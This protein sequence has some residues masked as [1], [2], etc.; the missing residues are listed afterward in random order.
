MGQVTDTLIHSGL[1][2]IGTGGIANNTTIHAGS[3]SVAGTANTTL[4]NSSATQTVTSGGIAND[5][6]VNSGG[7]QFISSGGTANR[8]E[9]YSA[10]S[11]TIQTGGVASAT[12]LHGG[13]QT[14]LSGGAANDTTINS[15]GLQTVSSGGI[16]TSTVIN[17]SGTQNISAGGSASIT[18][19]E[20]GG[21]QTVMG[22][23][24]DTTI[25]SGG[26]QSV[27]G[28]A[29]STLINGGI[30]IVQNAGTANNTSIGAGGVQTVSGTA[31]H[32]DVLSG[33]LQ[34]VYDGGSASSTTIRS[35]GDQHVFSGGTAR[36][37]VIDGGQQ[38]VL[39]Q[40][41]D[42]T[43][44]AGT[45]TIGSGGGARSTTVWSGEVHIQSAGIANDM[46]AYAGN[47]N[48]SSG[49]VINGTTELHGTATIGG[50]LITNEGI[51]LVNQDIDNTIN[52]SITGNGNLVKTGTGTL[53]LNGTHTYTGGTTLFTGTLL[54]G[55]T[56]AD[57]TAKIAG[58]VYVY[59]GSLGGFGNID[60]AVTVNNGG[61]LKP[62][63]G[64]DDGTLSVGSVH[65]ASGS[66][67]DTG[68]NHD[69]THSKLVASNTLGT[70]T[71]TIESG[72]NLA[73]H[74][75]P[76]DWS[77]QTTY[78][79]IDTSN[80]VTGTFT[81]V[82]SDL[83]FLNHSVDY[84]DLNKV[85][86]TMTR[87][88]TGFGDIGLTYN[89][90]NTGYGVESLGIGNPVY[91]QIIGM[92]R[93]EAINSFDNLSGE[94][95]ASTKSALFENSRYARDSVL[96]HLNHVLQQTPEA[97]RLLWTNVW[98]HDGHLKD[99]GNAT[100]LD[101]KGFG[102]M[103]GSDIYRDGKN[104]LGA[105]IGYEHTELSAGGVRNSTSDVDAVH[106]MGYGQTRLGPVD[107]KGGAGYS[108]YRI[109]T[110]RNISIGNI[111]SQNTAKYDAGMIQLFAEG[112]HRFDLTE[113]TSVTPYAQLTWQRIHTDSFT[114]K[115]DY[116][117]LHGHSGSDNA[118]GTTLGVRAEQA[119]N[120]KSRLYAD[121]GW[122]HRYGSIEP[123]SDMN[124]ATSRTYNIK[125]VQNNRNSA[126]IGLGAHME[127]QKNM[128][129]QL[130]YEGMFGN[131]I[132]DHALQVRVN[133]AF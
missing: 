94:I 98:G 61:T 38:V 31:S 3:Q 23:A 89:Q 85:K 80:G 59:G 34:N 95:H 82:S 9:I 21:Q 54:I 51:L 131:Q 1:Q 63:N 100:R 22:T 115:G 35:G 12:T 93:R 47:I 125:G 106:F 76:G 103:V 39:G 24:S 71:V 75:A 87:N 114:E 110:E 121:L 28:T 40:V 108:W 107:V 6:T 109:D 30:Q 124:F 15:A 97:N 99:D 11:Q 126:L 83:A 113:K 42:T 92:D 64:T 123:D 101:N 10:G 27:D 57:S 32:T 119:I 77:P 84:S 130:G 78:T 18:T 45:Q 132:R 37:T 118:L 36:A 56:A 116:A 112:S 7:R 46:I 25:N 111:Q 104:T 73:I 17:N 81:S 14:V 66:T 4:L 69:G 70:G 50:E 2:R 60:G 33:G 62:G 88:D 41:V 127:L 48:V 52:T 91:D 96:N 117:Q 68:V 90:R 49:G 133:W 55:G 29:S 20:S 13:T 79:I 44:N 58:P 16:A 43:L 8:S 65:F 67:F 53:T 72:S 129:L 86:L 122:Q 74:A 19:I 5:T 26:T 102:L 105:A 128:N 120:A